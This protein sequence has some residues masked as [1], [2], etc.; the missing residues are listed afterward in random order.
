MR[1]WNLLVL[2]LI[3]WLYALVLARLFAVWMHD[4]FFSHGIFVPA[5]ALLVLWRDRKKLKAI[6]AA[7]SLAGLPLV[8]LAL[9]MRNPTARAVVLSHF[10]GE[11]GLLPFFAPA[12]KTSDARNSMKDLVAGGGFEPPTFG[13]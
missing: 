10:T 6:E 7:P 12:V 2:P 13:L 3:A 9:L 5:F 8:G 4:P 11:A 1:Y